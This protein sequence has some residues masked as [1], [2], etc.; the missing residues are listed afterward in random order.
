M[1]DSMQAS[2]SVVKARTTN[3]L[4]AAAFDQIVRRPR[5]V[6]ERMRATWAMSFML[7]DGL[8]FRPIGSTSMLVTYS[9]PNDEAQRPDR[10][11]VLCLTAAIDR[12]T[13]EVRWTDATMRHDLSRTPKAGGRGAVLDPRHK[14]D[15]T[16][17][18]GDLPNDRWLSLALEADAARRD[19]SVRSHTLDLIPV[20]PRI[21]IGYPNPGAVPFFDTP[22]LRRRVAE[23]MDKS[24]KQLEHMDG[25]VLDAILRTE[26]ATLA[27]APDDAPP[28]ERSLVNESQMYLVEQQFIGGLQGSLRV[29]ED[30]SQ[31]TGAEI[32]NPRELLGYCRFP[33]P[34]PALAE[35]LGFNLERALSLIA[36]AEAQ[37]EEQ[38]AAEV[39]VMKLPDV[40]RKYLG[41]V[42]K[43]IADIDIDVAASDIN[44]VLTADEAMLATL[45]SDDEVQILRCVL[46]HYYPHVLDQVNDAELVVAI[47]N[48]PAKLQVANAA[49]IQVLYRDPRQSTE[50][51]FRFGPAELGRDRMRLDLTGSNWHRPARQ[52]VVTNERQLEAPSSVAA[53]VEVAEPV[54]V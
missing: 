53:G 43:V 39:N 36:D 42:A 37:A 34:A 23:H 24:V 40:I 11:T 12:H 3:P 25:S 45:A 27:I 13:A 10:Q 9:E 35:S 46:K 22:A 49:S 50:H 16:V 30:Y 26:M 31:L 19:A 44:H 5:K 28:G 8:A 18:K 52:E 33:N 29:F 4:A 15:P 54:G 1:N 51:C 14:L 6:N 41:P 2:Q 38:H 21:W 17:S 32:E 48:H 20:M 47:Q 7:K